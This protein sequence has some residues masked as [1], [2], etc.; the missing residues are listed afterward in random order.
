MMSYDKNDE[1]LRRRFVDDT[2]GALAA[3]RK[4]LADPEVVRVEV[5][6]QREVDRVDRRDKYALLPQQP[7]RQRKIGNQASELQKKARRRRR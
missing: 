5:V 6:K 1:L 3:L 7:V 2:D 4:E